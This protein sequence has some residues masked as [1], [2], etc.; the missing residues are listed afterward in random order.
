MHPALDLW[1]PELKEHFKT[2]TPIKCAEERDWVY[3]RNGT[4][5]ISQ[6]AREQHG[7]ITC[8]YIPLV[9]GT[10]V[11]IQSRVQNHLEKSST[12]DLTR[13]FGNQG[14]CGF[15]MYLGEFFILTTWTPAK[16]YE[17]SQ[18]VRPPP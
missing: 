6:T 3:V 11:R 15:C 8:D 1:H 5:R 18:W 12:S 7:I 16:R 4:F 17:S 2:F 14:P 9:R 10:Y 13:D